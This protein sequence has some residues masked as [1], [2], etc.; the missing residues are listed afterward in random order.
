MVELSG[1][2]SDVLGLL[3]E[4]EAKHAPPILHLRGD[5]QL[6]REGTRVAIV[7]ARHASEEGLR[8]ARRLARL[9]VDEGITVVSGLALGIDTAA[10]Q[11]ALEAGGRTI[12]VLGA[13]L[14]EDYP[15]QNRELRQLIGREHLLVSQFSAG[16][17]IRRGNFPQRNRTMALISDATVIVEAG[18]S[19]GSL[20]QGWEA[21]RLGR[22]LLLMQSLVDDPRLR[23]PREMMSYGADVLSNLGDL[24]EV[25][26][27]PRTTAIEA[28]AS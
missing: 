11:A 5:L 15:Q 9:L 6:L 10:H 19:S 20:S 22:P 18:D 23:W 8:R 12:A 21:L 7:G 28:L 27:S 25:V 14:D 17:P 13:P 16:Q 26:P 3:N 1:T 24:L 4:V 2:P